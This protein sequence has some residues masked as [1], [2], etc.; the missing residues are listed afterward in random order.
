[1][2]QYLDNIRGT[3]YIQALFSE[4]EKR[5]HEQSEAG[6]ALTADTFSALTKELYER[7]YGPDFVMDKAYELNWARIPHFYRNFYVY[8]YA[9][10]FAAAQALAQKIIAGNTDARDRFLEF[11]SRG[12]S[13]YPINLLKDAG[14]DMTSPEPLEATANLMGRLV[15]EMEALLNE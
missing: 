3:V 7:Y 12:S 2:N 11:L 14:V 10:G 5:F 15:D 6:E 4:L 13:D 8:Q 1:M 9:T